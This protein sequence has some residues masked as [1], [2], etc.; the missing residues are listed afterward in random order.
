MSQV[1]V[2]RDDPR[3]QTLSFVANLVLK[4][5]L[6]DA[7]KEALEEWHRESDAS[8]GTTASTGTTGD[9]GGRRPSGRSVAVGLALIGGAAYLAN[10]RG[11]IPRGPPGVGSGDGGLT[12]GPGD[13]EDVRTTGDEEASEE[14]EEQGEEAPETGAV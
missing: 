8:G 1:S 2:S 9:S 13:T 12:E 14:A 11:L 4:E 5:T 7:V 6:K 10:R 3:V